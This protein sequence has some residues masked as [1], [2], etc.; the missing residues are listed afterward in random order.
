MYER[1]K[2]CKLG[3]YREKNKYKIVW[4]SGNL[5]SRILIIGEAPGENEAK[6][7]KPF[8]GKSGQF[9]RRRLSLYFDIDK[10][11][12]TLNTILCRPPDNRSPM[13]EE[14]EACYQYVI[15]V[16]FRMHPQIVITAGKV[17]SNWLANL[18]NTDYDVYAITAQELDDV[19]FAWLP[20]YHPSYVM[21]S[22]ERIQ[23]FEK[24]LK[25]YKNILKYPEALD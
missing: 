5:S 23:K 11:A 20:L 15:P 12:Y 16:F 6:F 21:R 22:N 13:L 18:L 3:D 2:K 24:T 7:G 14:Q 10:D 17:A 8:I 9:F 25:S 19:C 4:G 1:C